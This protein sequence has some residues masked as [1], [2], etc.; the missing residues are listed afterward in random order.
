MIEEG[1]KEIFFSHFGNISEYS[2]DLTKDQVG[3]W[4]SLNHVLFFIKLEKKFKVKFSGMELAECNSLRK[5][6]A[7]L[8]EKLKN[9]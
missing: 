6:Y 5:V 9:G 2:L 1:L 4:N 8:Q 3:N 7:L